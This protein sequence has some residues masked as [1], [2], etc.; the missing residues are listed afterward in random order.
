MPNDLEQQVPS[1]GSR[2]HNRSPLLTLRR[3]RAMDGAVTAM[4]AGSE[5]EGDWPEGVTTDDME[6]AGDWISHQ[7]A[8]RTVSVRASKGSPA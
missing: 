2:A 5:G 1:G 7:I 4:L 3:L 6:A 8:M